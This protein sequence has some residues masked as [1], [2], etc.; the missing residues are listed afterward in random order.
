MMDRCRDDGRP[1]PD[2]NLVSVPLLYRVYLQNWVLTKHVR[3][4]ER[5]GIP[6]MKL[7]NSL[8]HRDSSRRELVLSLPKGHSE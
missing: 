1:A 7:S 5:R 8:H 4:A 2:R 3:G 6:M